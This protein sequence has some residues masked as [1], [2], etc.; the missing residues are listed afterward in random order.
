M[1]YRNVQY[2][3]GNL[4]VS[5]FWQIYQK[6]EIRT[7]KAAVAKSTCALFFASPFRKLKK[8]PSFLKSVVNGMPLF[9]KISFLCNNLVLES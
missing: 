9:L 3:I 2:L 4:F 1:S 7:S 5:I 8:R 6:Y